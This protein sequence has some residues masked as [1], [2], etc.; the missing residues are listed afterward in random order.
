MFYCCFCKVNYQSN[1]HLFKENLTALGDFKIF[2]LFWRFQFE[3]ETS[4]M[5][6]VSDILHGKFFV[7]MNLQLIFFPLVLEIFLPLSLQI[8][9]LAYPLFL[10]KYVRFSHFTL[11]IS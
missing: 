7:L 8:L 6:F 10:I 4:I 1:C 2:Y 9:P 5:D 11:P 3:W